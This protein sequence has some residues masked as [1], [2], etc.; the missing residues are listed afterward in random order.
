ME[1]P[2]LAA[3]V[4]VGRNGVIGLNGGLPWRL[5]SDLRM[6][7]RLTM[8][9]P[10]IMGRRTFQSLPKALDGRDN[11][12]VSSQKGFEAEGAEVFANTA[13]ALDRA[14]ELAGQRGVDEIMLIGGAALYRELMPL[15]D[16]VYWTAVE[17]EPAGDTTLDP[18][19]EAEWELVRREPIEQGPKDEYASELLVYERRVA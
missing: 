17:G 19:P 12:V 2:V 9:K 1:K 8:G 14:R 16:R 15:V 3:V 18:L 11:L 5:S 4:A 6:F 13:A 7:R 10:L